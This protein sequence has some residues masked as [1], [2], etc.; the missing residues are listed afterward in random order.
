MILDTIIEQK[1]RELQLLHQKLP[2]EMLMA[3]V[4]AASPA[5][6]FRQ[7]LLPPP[8]SGERPLLRVI[9]EIK[10]ASPSKGVLCRDFDPVAIARTYEAS[11]AAAI[12]VLTDREF[13]QGDMEYLR[14]V[15][16]ATS[17][18]LLNKDFIIDPYQIYRARLYGADAVLLIAAILNASQIARFRTIAQEL[19]MSALVEVHSAEELKLVLASGAELIGINNRNLQ[20]FEVSVDTTCQLLPAIPAGKIIVSESGINSRELMLGL[21][22]Q[23]VHAFLIGEVLMQSPD[24]GA[25]LRLLLN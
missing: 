4:Q 1:K 23:G 15:R 16:G 10:K 2:L 5:K 18:P 6:N 19:S 14:Q 7:A 22:Q 9:A 24:P 17:I 3:A 8:H 12:S 11:G 25:A 20:T 21:A 13:F